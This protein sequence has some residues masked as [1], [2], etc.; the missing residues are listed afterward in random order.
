MNLGWLGSA[1]LLVVALGACELD[2]LKRTRTTHVLFL[3]LL[4][5]L[6]AACR[7]VRVIHLILDNFIIHKS[8]VVRAWLREH[9]LQLRLHFL[10]PY[11]PNANRIERLWL[12]LHANVT[13]NHLCRTMTELMKAVHRYLAQR[14]DLA[15][16]LAHAA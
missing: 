1:L 16:V 7:G 6:L 12:D 5:A 11:C 4:W 2:V 10:P 8:R 9:R 15:A 13:R 14:F 3:N